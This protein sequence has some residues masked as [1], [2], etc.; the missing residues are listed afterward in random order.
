MEVLCAEEVYRED[1]QRPST[2][3]SADIPRV[4][5]SN[6][7]SSGATTTK[8]TAASAA[9]AAAATRRPEIYREDVQRP[10]NVFS[11]DIPL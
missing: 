4:G 11:A 8:T 1:M 10:S 3:F 2:V 5:S 9:A 7:L 6:L